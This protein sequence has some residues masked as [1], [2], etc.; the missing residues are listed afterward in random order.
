MTCTRRGRFG[1][2]YLLAERPAA[3]D[4]LVVLQPAE[5]I[6]EGATA[7]LES[8]ALDNVAAIF[9]AHVDRRFPVGQV[10]AQAGSLAAAADT[11][12]ITLNGRGAH[13]ARPHESADP[14]LGAGMLIVALQSIVSRR[15]NPSDSC[16]LDHC[17]HAGR[18]GI[19]HHTGNSDHRRNA[20]HSRSDHARVAG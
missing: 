18:D 7:M 19:E 11:F 3:G 12:R 5:E 8:G 9:G 20:P 16:R 4:V 13:G 15:L 6:G 17:D 10:V 1:A 2:A 14:V